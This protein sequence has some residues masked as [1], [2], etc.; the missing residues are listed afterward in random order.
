MVALFFF[1]NVSFDT[2]PWYVLGYE[3]RIVANHLLGVQTVFDSTMSTMNYEPLLSTATI[4]M[5]VY[6]VVTTAVAAVLF[7]Y[8]QI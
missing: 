5:S 8:R 4:M 2:E 1:L 7:R 6:G 3:S